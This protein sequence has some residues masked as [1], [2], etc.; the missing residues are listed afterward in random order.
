MTDPVPALPPA[1]KPRGAYVAA[2]VMNGVAHSAG[3]TPRVAGDLYVRGKV[4]DEVSLELASEAAGEPGA[5][6][7]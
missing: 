4:G 3:M 5:V 1:P 2:V 7:E 6:G